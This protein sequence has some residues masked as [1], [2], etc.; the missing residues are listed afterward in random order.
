MR[1]RQVFGDFSVLP[2]KPPLCV[3]TQRCLVAGDGLLK[4]GRAVAREHTPPRV[5]E[6]VLGPGPVLRELLFRANT[7][8]CL[9]AG[10]GLLKIGRAVARGHTPPRDAEV[11]LGAGPV[12]GELLFRENT[13][14]RLAAGDGLQM[15]RTYVPGCKSK[16]TA[17]IKER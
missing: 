11:V 13:Q 7:Q 4:I 2:W 14:R 8:R 10:D 16:F 15:V 1:G 5:A 9:V 12:L 17:Q 6:V 3:N